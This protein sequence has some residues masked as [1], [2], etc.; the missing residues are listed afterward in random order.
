MKALE[1]RMLDYLVEHVLTHL[2]LVYEISGERNND[3]VESARHTSSELN[4][5]YARMEWRPR[6]FISH[7]SKA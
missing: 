1:C 2:Q 3:D 6:V 5:A 4:T 7:E